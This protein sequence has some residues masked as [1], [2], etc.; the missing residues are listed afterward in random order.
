MNTTATPRSPPDAP[1]GLAMGENK[2]MRRAS[3]TEV[4]EKRKNLKLKVKQST[5]K[6]P[7][8]N[9]SH[10]KQKILLERW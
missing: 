6:N 4:Q 8:T 5:E 1:A 9:Q 7:L 3:G 10:S 2:R